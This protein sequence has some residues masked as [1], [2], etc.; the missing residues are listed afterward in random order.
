[1]QEVIKRGVGDRPGGL[2]VHP[3]ALW[4]GELPEEEGGIMA[5]AA[6][7]DQAAH[8]PVVADPGRRADGQQ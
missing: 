3:A 2:V 5:G 8:H 7:V 4:G 1:V 6:V